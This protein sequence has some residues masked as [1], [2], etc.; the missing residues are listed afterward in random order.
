MVGLCED[1]N[2]VTCRVEDVA[3]AAEGDVTEAEGGGFILGSVVTVF[4][5]LHEEVEANP[6][7]VCDALCLDIAVGVVFED[8]M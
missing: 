6:D 4:A 2:G 3:V 1:C 8:V 7:D 5:R